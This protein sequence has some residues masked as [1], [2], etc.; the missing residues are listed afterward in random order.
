MFLDVDGRRDDTEHAVRTDLIAQVAKVANCP[1]QRSVKKWMQTSDIEHLLGELKNQLYDGNRNILLLSGAYLEDQITLCALEALAMGFDVNFL[2]DFITARDPRL[3][4]SLK[5]RLI[6]AGAVPSS[7]CQML[8]M[9]Q[10]TESDRAIAN[11]LREL[12]IQCDKI[13]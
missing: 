4:P 6:Q 5:F 10:A 12:L 13:E 2:C 3:E 7:L 1:I 11:S 9:W 8:Y